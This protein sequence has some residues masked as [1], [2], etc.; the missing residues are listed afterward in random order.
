M[1]VPTGRGLPARTVRSI[2]IYNIRMARESELKGQFRLRPLPAAQ[3]S[4]G[5]PSRLLRLRLRALSGDTAGHDLTIEG[6][7]DGND[8]LAGV[9]ILM[10]L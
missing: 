4:A 1:I 5:F 6:R 7:D 8:K 9:G 10:T 2:V 3:T